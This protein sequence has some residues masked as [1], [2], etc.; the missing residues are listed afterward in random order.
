M[1]PK[2]RRNSCLRQ[3]IGNY[4]ELNYYNCLL[5]CCDYLLF[6]EKKCT[7]IWLICDS[8]PFYAHV[9]TCSPSYTEEEQK[10]NVE[11]ETACLRLLIKSLMCLYEFGYCL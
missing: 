5:L 4:V 3:A 8:L 2:I 10:T 7:M 1:S 6:S 9:H 11:S